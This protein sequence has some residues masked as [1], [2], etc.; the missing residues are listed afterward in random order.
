[1]LTLSSCLYSREG[2]RN[3]EYTD[4]QQLQPIIISF[5]NEGNPGRNGKYMRPQYPDCLEGFLE[6]RTT[7]LVLEGK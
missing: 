2:D 7:G 3:V 5:R 6:L 1:M 4:S